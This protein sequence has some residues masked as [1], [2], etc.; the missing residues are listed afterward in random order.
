MRFIKRILNA[1]DKT[2][3]EIVPLCFIASWYPA[4]PF[5]PEGKPDVEAII[6]RQQALETKL[7]RQYSV[8]SVVFGIAE[9]LIPIYCVLDFIHYKLINNALQSLFCSIKALLFPTKFV[10]RVGLKTVSNRQTLLHYIAAWGLFEM[11]ICLAEWA[12]YL[13]YFV[14]CRIPVELYLH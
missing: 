14:L 7:Q 12:I 9:S 13:S 6:H 10:F 3:A 8:A 4:L 2:D 5:V 1:I 11:Q